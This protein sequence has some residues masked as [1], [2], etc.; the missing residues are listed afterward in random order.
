MYN[1]WHQIRKKIPVSRTFALLVICTIAIGCKTEKNDEPIIKDNLLGYVDPFIGTGFHGHTFPGP[2][3]P[4]G[5]LQLSPDTKLNGWDASSGYHYADSTIYGFSHTHLSGTGIG[6]MGDVLLLPF[7]GTTKEKPIATFNKADEVAKVGYYAVTFNNYPVKAELATT[8]RV[9][10]HRYQYNGCDEKRL[11][12]DI[13]HILQRTWGH[14]NIYNELEIIDNKTIKGLKHSKGWADDHKVYFYAQFS[15]PFTVDEV[16]VDQKTVSKVGT[17]SGKNVYAYLSFN[18]LKTDEPLQVK[19]SISPVDTDGARLNMETELPDWD[20]D[21]VRKDSEAIWNKA[22]QAIKVST[23]NAANLKVFYTALYHSMIAPMIYQDVDGRYRGMD[24]K[25]HQASPDAPNYTVYSLWDTFRALHPL[26]TIIDEQRSAEWVNNL[27]LKYQQGDFLPMWPLASNYTGTMVGYPAVANIADALAKD[28]PGIDKSLAL[29]AAINSASYKPWLIENTTTPRKKAL[30]PLYNKYVNEN[31]HIPADKIIKSVSFGLEM[32]Y[33]DW[34]IAEIARQNNNDSLVAV[35]KERAKN[36]TH[37]F[38]A[39]TGFMRGKNEDGSWVTPFNPKYSSHEKAAYVEG[40]AWQWTW[41]VPH[42]VKGLI[43]LYGSKEAFTQKLDTLFTTSSEIEGEDA[44][45]DIT[46]LI[47]QYAHGNEPSH[48]IA[49]FY[50]LAGQPWKTQQLVDQILKEFYTPTPEGIIGNE[51]CGQMSAWYVLNA[52]GFYQ[53]TP[54]NP[55]YTIGRPLFDKVE[56]PLKSGKTFT[57]IAEKNSPDNKYVQAF[58]IN[59]IKQDTLVF[60]HEDIKAGS[61]LKIVMGN[62]SKI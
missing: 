23:E 18:T 49:Y 36:Y 41:F 31:K 47:G 51:D 57:I 4:H 38:D 37:Y 24:H 32:A 28:I 22:L 6:D 12:L 42:D 13:G 54:G 52:M 29:E 3:R 44:S 61:T 1:N 14:S 59:D 55:V 9:G 21:K 50:T 56:I 11:L 27:L 10:I 48:H 34:C 20:F 43:D 46:G 5:M 39:E 53:V 60:K 35:F 19:V 8:D 15:S 26:M 58:Y 25:I 33:Y 40:N 2:V 16:V 17:Y 30:M 7:T 62:Q 45:S